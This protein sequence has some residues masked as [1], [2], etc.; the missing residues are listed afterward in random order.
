MAKQSINRLEKLSQTLTENILLVT[1]LLAALIVLLAASMIW[2][3]YSVRADLSHVTRERVHKL[4]LITDLLEAAYNRHVSLVNFTL[5]N[6]PFER[7]EYAM[8]FHSN[9]YGVGKARIEFRSLPLDAFE[10]QNMIEQ[11]GLIRDIVALQDE[12]LD[13]AQADD[14]EAARKLLAGD[15]R[16]LDGQYD[17]TIEALRQYEARQIEA[18]GAKAQERVDTA[19][20]QSLAIAAVAIAVAVALS[21]AVRRQLRL[22][23]RQITE[24]LYA[25]R[26]S[27]EKLRHEAE[28]DPLTRLANRNLF[29]L[30]VREAIEQARANEREVAILYLD[31]DH[32]KPVNDAYGHDVGDQLL[33]IVAQRLAA[34]VRQNDTVARLGGDE[35]AILVTNLNPGDDCV[36][37]QETL[38]RRLANPVSIA[39]H[40]I[41]PRGSLGMA[42]YPRDGVDAESLVAVADQAM[43]EIKRR[44]RESDA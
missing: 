5:S 4:Q 44:R 34:S 18:A 36:H 13:R 9:G 35:F 8:T 25:L 26:V 15:L 1:G 16:T 33:Q 12:A 19:I 23:S 39:G 11:D 43:F 24:N 27:E 37:I 41:Q 32:F 40:L 42:M 10:S 31:M 28:H 29:F 6:D 2:Q 3:V 17:R 38:Q 30:R 7:D 14:M 21:L 22:K 20:R